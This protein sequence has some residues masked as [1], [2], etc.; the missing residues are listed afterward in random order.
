MSRSQLFRKMKALLDE[1]PS[2]F[3]R[4]FRL[5]KAKELLEKGELNVSEVA[6]EIGMSN[7]PYFSKIYKERF[8]ELPSATNK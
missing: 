1:S 6:W 4:N 8:G 5:D 7:L 3:I 2:V